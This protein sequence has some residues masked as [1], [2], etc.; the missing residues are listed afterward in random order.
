MASID[1][2]HGESSDEEDMITIPKDF[3]TFSVKGVVADVVRQMLEYILNQQVG[4]HRI[5]N[6]FAPIN[7][8]PKA[9]L[10]FT[11]NQSAL[12]IFASIINLYM[13]KEDPIKKSDDIMQDLFKF[14]VDNNSIPISNDYTLGSAICKEFP[15]SAQT[16]LEPLVKLLS[17]VLYRISRIIATIGSEEIEPNAEQTKKLEEARAKRLAKRAESGKPPVVRKTAVSNG[18]KYNKVPINEQT[19][20]SVFANLISETHKEQSKTLLNVTAIIIGVTEDGYQ[21]ALD[22]LKTKRIADRLA[23]KKAKEAE[24]SVGKPEDADAKVPAVVA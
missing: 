7:K 15:G 5:S 19:V 14:I 4:E 6:I 20:I 1:N 11:I 16:K 18:K 13:Q 23:K 22:D 9:R 24:V 10:P 2:T 21:K 12:N 8:D 3:I 17:I